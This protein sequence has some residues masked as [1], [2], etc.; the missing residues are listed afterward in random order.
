EEAL[1]KE[2][3]LAKEKLKGAGFYVE[4]KTD[5]ARLTIEVMKKAVKLGALALNYIKVIHFLYDDFRKINGVIV[6]DQISGEQFSIFAKK[7]INATG[8]WVDEL[9]DLDGSKQGKTLH[10]TK[11]VHLVFSKQR[12]P[13][14][15]AIY[16]DAP[17]GRMIFAIPRENKTYVGTTD[18]D[19]EG[20]IARPLVT[21]SDR[22]YLIDAINDLFPSI[23]MKASDVESSWAGLRPLIADDGGK[24]PGEIS[25]KDEIFVSDSGLISMAGG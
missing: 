16:F 6:E 17:D 15:Q 11:G 7:I 4:Y 20:N 21:E 9:R 13:L 10:L 18:T 2:P 1:Q 19:Y 25:R 24:N 12:F 22:D 23:Q 8:P 5:D 3:L 14:Q